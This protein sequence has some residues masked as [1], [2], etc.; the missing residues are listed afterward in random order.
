MGPGIGFI[1]IIMAAGLF[2]VSLFYSLL[3][4][5]LVKIFNKIFTSIIFSLKITTSFFIGYLATIVYLIGVFIFL[6][7]GYTAYSWLVSAVGSL[8]LFFVHSHFL[9]KYCVTVT[10]ES[11]TNRKKW[12]F[13]FAIPF[14]ALLLLQALI[15]MYR[16]FY[17]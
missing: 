16:S 13:S 11:N 12:L 17:V 14:I 4:F 5:I 9:L 15:L 10:K 1:V 2:I 7:L 3:V 6:Y 8:I